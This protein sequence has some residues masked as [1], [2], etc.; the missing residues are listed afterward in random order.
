MGGHLNVCLNREN[1]K[2]LKA[3][4]LEEIKLIKF[5]R[6]TKLPP[7]ALQQGMAASFRQR[8]PRNPTRQ[9]SLGPMRVGGLTADGKHLAKTAGL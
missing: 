7:T 9:V 8:H 2:T 3:M 5:L 4:E 1:S 6:P